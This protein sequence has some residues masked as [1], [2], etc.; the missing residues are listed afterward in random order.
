MK[1]SLDNFKEAWDNFID[2]L[3][4]KKFIIKLLE[5]LNRLLRNI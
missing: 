5:M 3:G 4:F 1:E 2:A